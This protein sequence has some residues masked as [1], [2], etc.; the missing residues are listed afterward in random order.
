MDFLDPKKRRANTIKLFIGYCLMALL[1]VL[2]TVVLIYAANGYSLDT[3]TGQVIQNGLL[4]V[5]SVPAQS[6]VFLDDKEQG[7]TEQRLVLPESQYTIKVTKPGYDT[8]NK[9]VEINGGS[10]ERHPYVLLLPQDIKSK[11]IQNYTAP[12]MFISG[13]NGK[14]WVIAMRSNESNVIDK[15]D[16]SKSIIIPSTISI[17]DSIVTVT[18]KPLTYKAMEWS[19]DESHVLLRRTAEGVDE[20]LVL[21]I[22]SP[23]KSVNINK[24]FGVNPKKLTFRDSQ[25]N[26]LY[27][28][29]LS[30]NTLR[31]L[32]LAAKTVSTPIATNVADYTS[33]GKD[34]I[35]YKALREGDATKTDIKI[36]TASGDQIIKTYTTSATGGE[37]LAIGLFENNWYYAF[38]IPSEEKAFIYKNPAEEILRNKNK[39][40]NP[41]QIYHAKDIKMI[42]VSPSQ[43]FISFHYGTTYFV[44][45]VETSRQHKF[46][47]K[48]EVDPN[49]EP[50]W[51]DGFRLLVK[52]SKSSNIF[53][54]D[55]TNIR[56]LTDQI[57]GQPFLDAEYNKFLTLSNEAAGGLVLKEHSLVVI[58]K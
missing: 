50:V 16:I 14:K 56:K 55:G 5:D 26:D 18:D 43:R 1:L 4:F 8:W 39:I 47:L 9:V 34:R 49:F 23:D 33:F 21:D 2:G 57:I 58:E 13:S 10:I 53:D 15:Y 7:K 54:F 38:N 37:Q 22:N 28:L 32:D 51:L 31:R 52:D 20:Y 41:T 17:P 35:M 3:N 42:G 36:T 25:S 44:Y 30:V 12:P 48:T 6:T 27:I 24:T 29:E 11:N 45:D 40:V 46:V 19:N